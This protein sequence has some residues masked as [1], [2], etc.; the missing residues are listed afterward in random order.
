M[1]GVFLDRAT[2]D[3]GD[4]DLTPLAST[5]AEW[6]FH[7]LTPATAVA[8][9]LVG[10]EVV[11]SNKTQLDADA[12]ER[13]ATLRLICVSATG[14]N[15]VDLDAARRRGIQVC[16]VRSYA[17]PSVVE[18]VFALILA[19]RRQLPA[20]HAAVRAGHWQRSPYFALLD[21]PIGELHG[22]TLGIVGYGELGRA[23][24]AV[25]TAFGMRVMIAARSHA[26]QPGRVGLWDVLAQA[27][28]VS[29]HTPLTA[30]TR[31]LIGAAE[32]AL[33]KSDALLINTARGG[34]VDEEAL[35]AALR[36]GR[37]GGAGVDVL[38]D[39]PPHGGN[40]LLVPDIPNLI[41]TPHVAW[42][43]RQAR[44]RLIHEVAANITAFI[45]GVP[46]NVVI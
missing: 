7:E 38:S 1:R 8:E 14:T 31:G 17:T 39:E 35:A 13:A 5:L 22:N 33:M 18:H 27:D 30:E 29:L 36:A 44:Q 24:A 34:I 3:P 42:A 12:L 32:L 25:A 43:S 11:V 2:L 28:V 4:I 21:F 15:N 20:Y 41:V 45:A 37:L 23:V 6:S 19:L 16:N 10:A 26:A 40:P 9:R 46:R